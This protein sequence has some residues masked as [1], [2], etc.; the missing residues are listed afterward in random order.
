[1]SLDLKVEPRNGYMLFTV[2]GP[3]ELIAATEIVMRCVGEQKAHR[4]T[5]ALS[6]C[7]GVTGPISVADRFSFGV[8]VAELHL[9][10][11]F[12]TKEK[13]KVAFVGTPEVID[14]G[15]LGETVAINRGADVRATTDMREAI[16][17]LGMGPE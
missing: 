15:R 6:D 9:E 13:L 2:S 5:K 14:P 17:W 3:F 8:H 1:M 7:R 11:L 12:E 16:A 4:L 10:H